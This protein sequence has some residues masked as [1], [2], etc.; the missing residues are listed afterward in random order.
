MTNYIWADECNQSSHAEA[1]CIHRSDH[2]HHDQLWG[3]INFVNQR[4]ACH[5]LGA[6][7]LLGSQYCCLQ[8][9][10]ELFI[11][12]TSHL[13][14]HFLGFSAIHPPSVK[15]Y[16]H[17]QTE[18]DSFLGPAW[19]RDV[20]YQIWW[21]LLKLCSTWSSSSDKWCYHCGCCS[22]VWRAKESLLWNSSFHLY[23]WQ[24]GQMC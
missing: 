16:A 21:R 2:H 20:L 19:S 22:S 24:N 15:S 1:T 17:T 18:R 9:S 11:R 4:T 14:L 13:T 8:R 10:Q 12:S 3:E 23:F 5:L 6:G 7:R